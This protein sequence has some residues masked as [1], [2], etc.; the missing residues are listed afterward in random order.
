MIIFFI[1]L[2]ISSELKNEEKETDGKYTRR[3]Y[4]YG[5][6]K[7]SFTLPDEIVAEK[8]SAEYTNGELKIHIPKKEEKELKPKTIKVK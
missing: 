1:I 8:I 5:E 7:R 2:S 6:F 3:E 4:Y